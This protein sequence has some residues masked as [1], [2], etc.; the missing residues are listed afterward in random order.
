MKKQLWPVLHF[1]LE[2]VAGEE[3]RAYF[4]E[5]SKLEERSLPWSELDKNTQAKISKLKLI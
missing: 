4:V 1:D 5:E 3:V 2:G